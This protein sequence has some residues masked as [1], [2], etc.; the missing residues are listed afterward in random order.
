LGK[1]AMPL[2]NRSFRRRDSVSNQ[3]R[4]F[5]LSKLNII[6]LIILLISLSAFYFL[7]IS[8]I[9]KVKEIS[10]NPSNTSCTSESEIKKFT[11][12]LGKSIFFVDS[13]WVNQ[14]ISERFNCIES[15]KLEKKFPNNLNINLSERKAASIVKLIKFNSIPPL[16][17]LTESLASSS[18]EATPSSN[19]AVGTNLDFEVNES[20]VSSKL[21]TD[22]EGFILLKVEDENQFSNLPRIYLLGKDINFSKVIPNEFVG[23]TLKVLEKMN[24]L[25]KNVERVKIVDNSLFV[26][27][28]EKIVFSL[29]KDILRQL[30]SLQLI[31]QKAKIESKQVEIIDLRFDKP[32]VV[33]SPKK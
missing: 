32:V 15:A 13:G 33:Y 24:S 6:L 31:L 4:S 5:I 20:S 11:N 9:F 27:S 12:L 29:T 22:K 16:V 7:Y 3:K 8:D 10:V 1:K 26:K 2:I 21:L 28:E 17:D 30:A 23:N 25:S 19:T 18:S 14:K